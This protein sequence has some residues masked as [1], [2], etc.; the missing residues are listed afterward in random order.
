[1]VTNRQARIA[2]SAIFASTGIFLG[3]W[4]ARIADVK[5]AFHLTDARLGLILA[6]TTVGSVAGSGAAGFFSG[7]IGSRRLLRVSAPLGALTYTFMALA[8]SVPL[9]VAALIT[10]GM[11]NMLVQVSMNTQAI[12]LEARYRRTILTTMHGA[13]SIGM[14]AGALAAAGMSQLGVSYRAGLFGVSMFLLVLAFTIGFF[15]IETDRASRAHHPRIRLTLPLAIILVVVFFELFCE[16]TAMTWTSVYMKDSIHAA[17]LAALAVGVYSLTMTAGR[18]TGD[19]L[20]TRLGVGTLVGTGASI[21]ALGLGLALVL[22]TRESA[23]IGFGLMGIGLS[24][25]TPTLF[26]AAGQLPLPEGQGVAA[27]M[28]AGF[29][30][31]LLVSPVIGGLSSLSSLRIALT[32][33]LGA[34]GMMIA[35][36]G[37]LGRLAPAP[38]ASPEPAAAPSGLRS[39]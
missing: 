19:R 7:R 28:F 13:F 12:A 30:A 5:S 33:T 3:T 2:L 9:L 4:S 23:L 36:S 25:Q 8:P 34:A 16:G 1:M 21:A 31:F 18:L 17:S 14:M 27:A 11:I 35:L 39:E 6:C 32:I 38:L 10:M 26:R 37:V 22:H 15:L 29:P 20:I 24:C